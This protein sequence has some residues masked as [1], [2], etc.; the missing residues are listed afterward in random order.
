MRKRKRWFSLGLLW[1]SF[2][3]VC[4]VVILA[5]QQSLFFYPWHDQEAYEQLSR[6]ESFEEIN[7]EHNGGRLNGWLKYNADQTQAPLMIFFG[8][9]GQN[10][11]NTCKY[12]KEHNIFRN[13]EGYHFLYVD[14]PGY[15][16]SDGSPSDTTMF[17][18][19]LR[20]YDYACALDSVDSQ[21]IVVLGYSIGTGVATY[22]ASQRAANGL[23]LIAPYDRGLSLYNSELN[24]F[25][26]PLKLLAKY[27]FDSIRYAK[28][29]EVAPL[30]IASYDDEVIDEKL[31]LN[32]AKYFANIEQTLLLEGV[33]H[34]A[35]FYHRAVLDAI[36]DYLQKRI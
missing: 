4:V 6:T 12:F 9:N 24:I 13:F 26:G 35:F 28:S 19:A 34:D 14:Y 8:G 5:A 21:K 16:L 36:H 10:S 18:A 7:I 23:I 15:G 29:V 11:S 3:V 1:I 30:I 27:K 33:S 31:S 32:L 17:A 25:H 20:I 2:L 22:V